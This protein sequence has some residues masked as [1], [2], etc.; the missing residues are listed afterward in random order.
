VSNEMKKVVCLIG[1]TA[2]GK[3]DLALSLSEKLNGEIVNADSRQFYKEMRIGTAKP[4]ESVLSSVP[5]HL[6]DTASISDPWDVVRFIKEADEKIS[7]VTERHKVPIVVGG[8]GMYV[9]CLLFGIDT[10]PR[11]SQSIIDSLEEK[12]ETKGTDELYNELLA[13]DAET[14]QLYSRNDKQRIT[15]A[16]GVF[17]QTGKSIRHYWSEE[18]KNPRYDYLKI[19]LNIEREELYD[20]INKRV[21]QMMDAGLE[22][23]VRNLCQEDPE[24]K[25]LHSTIGYREWMELG[26]DDPSKVL[27]TIQKASRHFAK[28]QLTWFRKEDDI[29]WFAPNEVE[30]ITKKVRE[31]LEK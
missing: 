29:N 3:T 11:I 5:H 18:K 14:A 25:M 31:F 10:I 28:R 2:V 9:K 7:E 15:R 6:V 30:L 4:D 22:D 24:N 8:T 13:V 23:E 12:L 27:E 21:V 26:F 1:P 17:R 16:L 20:R 19:G